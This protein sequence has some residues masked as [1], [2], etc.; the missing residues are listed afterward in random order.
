[1]PIRRD[2]RPNLR[3]WSQV[4]PPSLAASLSEGP[5]GEGR[6]RVGWLCLL[7]T[8]VG[9]LASRAS[10]AE[11]ASFEVLEREY[12]GDIHPLLTRFCLKCHSTDRQEGELDLERFQALSVVRKAPRVWQK[13]AEMLDNG[14]MPPKSAKKPSLSER[15]QLRGWVERYLHAEAHASAGDPGPVVLR[16]LSNAQYTYTVRDL[17][18]LG[19][20]APAR[21]FPAD[22]AAGEGF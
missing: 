15:K 1:M 3:D 2:K 18:G 19:D 7:A 8:A 13:V 17:T 14:E 9:L 21:E 4:L 11:P 6:N 22:G 20:L 12:A 10:A 16:R 5:K